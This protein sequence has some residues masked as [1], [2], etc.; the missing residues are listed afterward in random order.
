MYAMGRRIT[1]AALVWL[2]GLASTSPVAAQEVVE[3]TAQTAEYRFAEAL[4]F[5]AEFTST[6]V[7]LDGYVFYQVGESERIWVYEGDISRGRLDVSVSLDEHNQPQAFTTIRYW[8]RIASDHGEF[9]ESPRYTLYYEDNR[10]DWQQ[11]QS[12]PFTMYWHAGGP[13]FAVAVLAAAAEGV[14]NVQAV[15][16]LPAPRPVTLRVYADAADLQRA[17]E[18]AG[19]PWAASHMQ[20]GRGVLLFALAPDGEAE[21]MRQVRHELAH[22]T[23]YDGL[24][25]DG[26]ANLP[27]WLNEG[28]ATLAEGEPDPQQ[29]ALLHA[30][31]EAGALPPLYSLCSQMPQEAVAAQIARIQSGSLVRYLVQRFNATGFAILVEAYARSGDC[32]NA[33]QA[34]FGV[35]LLQLELDWRT[36]TFEQPDPLAQVP[37]AAIATAAGVAA[38]LWLLSRLAARSGRQA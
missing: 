4:D 10:F 21:G 12:A 32:L 9:F 7:I 6:A 28:I 14:A 8:F 29:L 27:A 19:Y 24:G 31:A 30:A 34:A 20:P 15:L 11:A 3:F 22:L 37:W 17:A 2:A 38:A 25:A 23:L 35:D 1:L 13:D 26:Y 5:S 33:P 36:A 16:P 18:L